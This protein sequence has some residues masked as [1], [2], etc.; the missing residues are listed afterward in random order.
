MTMK[1]RE[2]M[3][4]LA[5]VC[6]GGIGSL[7]HSGA[8]QVQVRASGRKVIVIGSGLA[9]LGA[10]QRLVQAGCQVI[11]LEARGRIGGRTWTSQHWP[12][13]P[14]DMGAS[15][16][17]G[18]EGNPITRLA[19]EAKAKRITTRYGN[20][21]AY[22]EN[23]QE[24]NAADTRLYRRI[25]KKILSAVESAQNRDQDVSILDAVRPL[26]RQYPEGSRESLMLSH[27]LN[28]DIEH[29]FAGSAANLSAFW[30]DEA[31]SYEGED[32]LF[33][34]GYRVITDLLA[35]GLDIRT[36]Q[37]VESI[38]WNEAI[39][40]VTTQ[41][42]EYSADNVIITVPLGVLKQQKIHFLP[43]LPEAKIQA[44]KHLGM[45][46]LNKCYL[47]FPKVF[48]PEKVDWIEYLAPRH[49][50]WTEWVNF[51]QITGKP[52]LLGFNAADMG[53]AI[54]KWSDG[55]IISSAMKT[56]RRMFG[57]SIP[58]PVDFQITRWGSDPHTCGSYSFNA[59][60]SSPSM[61]DTLAQSL[62][63]RLHFA[64]EATE[65]NYFATTHGA[66]LSGLRAAGEILNP[67]AKKI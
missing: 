22:D 53:A 46:V 42:G 50:E 57:S 58:D 56:L 40:R 9:G 52:V 12:D 59:V 19:D 24:L 44:I 11:V 48:W 8:G 67:P 2:W 1:R 63:G 43:Q 38:H 25:G 16:I 4:L 26:T 49:G 61:R 32:V 3:K 45:G 51:S 64:G 5:L 17:H 37:V 10:A 14:V 34:Q 36:H 47:R 15:W 39:V 31:K 33:P 62:N 20:S 55:E 21:V 7:G 13:L 60:G 65:K 30:C 27:V 18:V 66:Y 41:T 23:G 54:E 35:K 29:E 28:S 6:A